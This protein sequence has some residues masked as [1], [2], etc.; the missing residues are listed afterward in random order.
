MLQ[1]M[2]R[3]QSFTKYLSSAMLIP[4]NRSKRMLNFQLN[5]GHNTQTTKKMSKSDPQK[6]PVYYKIPSCN[7][8]SIP[9]IV[10]L[11]M[12]TKNKKTKQKRIRHS[13]EKLAT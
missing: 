8:Y 1:I 3:M 2:L 12:E 7:S 13:P 5:I 10:V 9:V 6:V 11:V 4:L